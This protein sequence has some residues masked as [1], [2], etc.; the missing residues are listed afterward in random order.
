MCTLL[1]SFFVLLEKLFLFP[2]T[3]FPFFLSMCSP[4]ILGRRPF[5]IGDRIQI[6]G[7]ETDC[8]YIVDLL[9]C[10]LYMHCVSHLSLCTASLH[11]ILPWTVVNVTL[12]ET[13]L[14]Y[15]PTNER[16]S[17]SNG[18]LAN[19]RIVN[20]A[21]RYEQ[22]RYRISFCPHLRAHQSFVLISVQPS[23]S[24]PYFL[25]IS[26]RDTVSKVGPVQKGRRGVHACASKG[27]SK[28]CVPFVCAHLAVPDTFWIDPA[29]EWRALNGFRCNMVYAKENY[30]EYLIVIQ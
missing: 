22:C 12:F 13:T 6:G 11:G 2:H 24:I 18:S 21:R 4:V 10:N 8:K 28:L 7:V 29:Q 17:L 23:S 26:T 27:R 9:S 16:A 1:I 30:M 25:A 19:S 20:W 15:L 3:V 14:V 5:G